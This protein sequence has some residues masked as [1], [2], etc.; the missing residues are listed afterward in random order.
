MCDILQDISISFCMYVS[1]RSRHFSDVI[2]V[3]EDTV[4]GVRLEDRLWMNRHIKDVEIY[5][6]SSLG[7]A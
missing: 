4:E 3:D 6:S 1:V 7:K 5:L 2:L